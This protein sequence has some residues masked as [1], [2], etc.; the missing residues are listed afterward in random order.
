MKLG[1]RLTAAFTAFRS[2]S[3]S[4][5]AFLR[6]DEGGTAPGNRLTMPYAQSAWVHAA[7]NHVVDEISGRPLKFYAGDTE[8]EDAAL[9]AWWAAPALGPMTLGT[10]QPRLSL[11][12]SV[13]DLAAWAKLEGEFFICFDDAWLLAGASRNYAALKPFLI[14]K[15]DRM[16]LIVQ[17]GQLA[18]YRYTDVSGRQITFLPEQVKHWKAFNPYDDWRGLGAMQA[19]RVAAEGAFLTGVYIRELMRNNGDQGMIVIGKSGIAQDGQREQIV[20]DL[21]AK[22]NALRQGIARDLFLTGDITV[23]RPKEQAAST[24]LTAGKALSHQEVFV[25][26]GVPPSMA[27]VKASYSVGKDSDYYQLI[28]RT[29]QPLGGKIA[30]VFA[31]IASRQTGKALTA[32][33]EWDDHPVMVEVR[34]GR[35]TALKDL[36]AMGMP[37]K[38]ANEFLSLGMQPFAGWD[39][40]YLPFSVAPVD[41][42]LPDS[43]PDSAETPAAVETQPVEEDNAVKTLR[44][45]LLARSRVTHRAKPVCRSI[46]D[47][48][49]VFA[50]NHGDGIAQRADR[51][52]REV[53][54]WRTYMSQRRETLRSYES[55]F[56][57]ELMK[58]R[59]ETL[60]N[61]E[62]ATKL[63]GVAVM[64]GKAG[65]IVFDL[66]KFRDSLFASFKKMG[67][68]ALD[69]AG[70][71]LFKELSHEDPFKYPPEAVLEFVRAR[72]NKLSGVPQEVFDR[73][74]ESLEEGFINGDTAEQLADRVRTE[75]NDISKRR[76]RMIA[77]TETGAAYGA[78]RAEGMQQAGVPGKAWLT[79]GNDNV[80][81]AHQ[82]AG[83]DYSPDRPI[84]LDAPFIVDGEELMYPG[85]S[86][87]SP[88][89]VIQCHC[90][91][92]PTEKAPE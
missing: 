9:E 86:D 25:A 88:E 81:A 44:L 73:V 68:Q 61:L 16:Q 91:S 33:F 34:N 60:A 85:D 20:A 51:P 50:C 39:V 90:V 35:I 87:G 74:K 82:Q 14:A 83:L 15:P 19:A 79:S 29:C 2:K 23:E 45:A 40:G 5:A 70:K 57:R 59:S 18:G 49:A 38:D 11:E 22:R 43:Q 69:A 65:E 89:N 92:I 46:D 13:R 75:F 12:D 31:S 47:E 56:N 6:G 62:K 26:F 30:G 64:K 63:G 28:T 41:G 48:F 3:F 8:F 32:E 66:K 54:Q 36:W 76:A 21:R 24:D 27:E 55:R 17:G 71:Q 53:A 84:A 77:S 58:A 52:A 42:G 67:E 80:R 37:I 10:T 72:E 1:Q 7:V 4:A 78:G